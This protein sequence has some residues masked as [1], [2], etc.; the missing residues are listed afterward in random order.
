[1]L[2]DDVAT[3]LSN[4]W[5]LMSFGTSE[6]TNIYVKFKDIQTTQ[7]DPLIVFTVELF[8]NND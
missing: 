7:L 3:D 4:G 5:I 1:M 2:L 6:G 8:D